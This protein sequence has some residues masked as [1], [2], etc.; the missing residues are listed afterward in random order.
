M[1]GTAATV[2]IAIANGA[3]CVRVHDVHAMAR[4]VRMTDAI[5]Y[6]PRK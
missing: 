2:A 6:G 4:V 5:V 1:E 3:A